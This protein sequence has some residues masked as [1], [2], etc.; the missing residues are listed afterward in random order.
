MLMCPPFTCHSDSG[1]DFIEDEQ[2]FVFIAQGSYRF[3]EFGS[4]MVVTALTLNRLHD[5]GGDVIFVIHKSFF[6][7]AH[8]LFF[9]LND[10]IMIFVQR[11]I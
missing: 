11:E 8:S 2:H 7:F 3:E 9:E 10:F 1:L 5:E 4:E 6:N